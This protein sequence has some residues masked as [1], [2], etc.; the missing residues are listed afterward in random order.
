MTPKISPFDIFAPIEAALHLPSATDQDKELV[1]V[2]ICEAVR[3]AKKPANNIPAEE[4][5]AFQELKKNSDI[6]I[7]HADKG[8]ATVVLNAADYNRK[9]HDLLDDDKSYTVL[10]KD[11]TRSTERAFLSLLR[12]LRKEGKITE[13]FYNKVRPSEGSSKPALFYGRVKLH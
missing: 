12:N 5:K 9:A 7:L 13:D 2:K 6:Q 3:K 11:P 4:R 10:T 8:N 1:R